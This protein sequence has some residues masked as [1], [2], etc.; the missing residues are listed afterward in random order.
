MK[1]VAIGKIKLSDQWWNKFSVHFIKLYLFDF[2]CC[3]WSILS[4]VWPMTKFCIK[5]VFP[6]FVIL[7]IEAE[8]LSN[9]INQLFFNH[10]APL[11]NRALV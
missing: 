8:T 7:E 6:H 4:T 2:M 5:W 11:Q 1:W 3:H 10:T 9:F